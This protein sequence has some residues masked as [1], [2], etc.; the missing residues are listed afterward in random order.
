[1][2]GGIIIPHYPHTSGNVIVAEA[3]DTYTPQPPRLLDRLR[4]SIR[5]LGYSRSTE[6]AYVSWVRRYVRFHR[7]RHPSKMGPDEIRAFVEHLAVDRNVSSS[8]I[9]QALSALLFLYRRVLHADPGWIDGIELARRPVRLP[10]VLTPA[11]VRAVLAR[12][13]GTSLLMASIMYGS[14][15]RLR[16]C[17]TLRV[18]DVDFERHEI[19]VRQGKGRKDRVTPLAEATSGQLR[20]QIELRRSLHARD[21]AEGMGSVALPMALERKSPGAAK[22]WAWQW[23][24]PA[25][26]RHADRETGELRRHHRHESTLQR[27]VRRAVLASG[28]SK[29]ATC[30]TLR[31]SFATHLL[32]SGT[33][34][35]TIQELLGH[36]D[37]GTTMI[38]THVLNRGALGVRSPMDR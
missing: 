16:E 36:R 22:E 1:M 7:L 15:L 21:L 18:K 5:R 10:V 38:Y 11:E 29:R 6:K 37:L 23:V 8:T 34:I 27:D 28:I 30:H 19:V 17:C 20:R 33:D 13:H 3:S 4:A 2:V 24:F 35:R 9:N 32:E 12:L 14:G 26:R 25:S 31:H